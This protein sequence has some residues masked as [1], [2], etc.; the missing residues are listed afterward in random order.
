MRGAFVAVWPELWRDLWVPLARH[1]AF[2]DLFVDL[3]R[4]FIPPPTPLKPILSM[5]AEELLAFRS[6]HQRY[7]D[8]IADP[9]RARRAFRRWLATG[10]GTE[11]A[12]LAVLDRAHGVIEAY[13]DAAYVAAYVSRVERVIEKFNLRY[14]PCLPFGLHPTLPGVFAALMRAV[15]AG[16][17][18]PAPADG[19]IRGGVPRPAR[20]LLGRPHQDLH[21]EAGQPD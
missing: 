8:V 19:G 15:Q 1:P 14:D 4:E 16:R 12:A 21:P 20:R 11:S 17:P 6:V 9:G 3:H 2:A 13:G 5:D 7:E 10:V 18:A